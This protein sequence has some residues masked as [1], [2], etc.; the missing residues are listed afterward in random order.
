MSR[1]LATGAAGMVGSYL[2]PQVVGLGRAELD[3]SDL[4]AVHATLERER[5]DAVIHLAAATDVER[6]EEDRDYA[7]TGNTLG[8]LHVAAACR[9]LGIRMA[10][11]S[12]GG[13]FDGSKMQF[14]EDDQPNPPT[15]Y[16]WTKYEGERIVSDLVPAPLVVRAGWI[17]GGGPERDHKFVGALVRLF[18]ERDLVEVVADRHGS[19]TYARHFVAALIE[20]L[21]RGATGTWHCAN[22]GVCSRYDIAQ[23]V[24]ERTAYAGTL[25]AVSSDRFPTKAPRGMSEGLDCVKLRSHDLALPTWRDALVEYLEEFGR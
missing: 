7:F 17:M 12:T 18:G 4:D 13:V 11:V 5:P 22:E 25:R 16:A 2:P 15:F 1:Y 21:D 23:V 19:P 10:Y 6:S 8:T 3:V 9:A 24:A 14:S 20:L